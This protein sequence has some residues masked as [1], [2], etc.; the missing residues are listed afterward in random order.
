MLAISNS[1]ETCITSE[2]KANQFI[3]TWNSLIWL[4]MIA[5][6]ESI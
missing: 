4:M 1:F 3:A 2:K 5:Q 6:L